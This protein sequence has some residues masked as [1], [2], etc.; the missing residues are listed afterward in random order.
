MYIN[1]FAHKSCSRDL[2][3]DFQSLSLDTLHSRMREE[4]LGKEAYIMIPVPR[5]IFYSFVYP[6]LHG[7]HFWHAHYGDWAHP[8][9]Q[10]RLIGSI[11]RLVNLRRIFGLPFVRP[12]AQ[13]DLSGYNTDPKKGPVCGYLLFLEKGLKGFG[14]SYNHRQQTLKFTFS[15]LTYRW[16]SKDGAKTLNLRNA[17]EESHGCETKGFP[18]IGQRVRIFWIAWNESYAATVKRW[19]KTHRKWVLKYDEWEDTVIEDVPVVDWEF[20]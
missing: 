20:E 14:F 18:V 16:C 10:T 7:V 17:E 13:P 1:Q 4:N 5:S 15:Y 3:K 19:S 12:R 2:I 9:F 6:Q 11:N 8:R